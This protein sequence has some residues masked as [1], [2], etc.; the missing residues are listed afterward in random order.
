MPPTSRS[1][2]A[3]RPHLVVNDGFMYQGWA[4]Y[5]PKCARP[6]RLSSSVNHSLRRKRG[7]GRKKLRSANFLISTTMSITWAYMAGGCGNLE[8]GEYGRYTM[9]QC[10]CEPPLRKDFDTHFIAFC[11]RGSSS[12]E[13]T[14]KPKGLRAEG[15]LNKAMLKVPRLSVALVSAGT[16]C[17]FSYARLHTSNSASQ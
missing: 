5:W 1:K 6:V 9:R 11:K 16:I 7:R 17:W 13:A 15:T 2:R 4:M 8:S 12:A 3:F 14:V 10:S